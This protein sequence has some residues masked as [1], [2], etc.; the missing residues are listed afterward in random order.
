MSYENKNE[1]IIDIDCFDE[2]AKVSHY[3]SHVTRT[4]LNYIIKNVLRDC[5]L[6]AWSHFQFQNN[7]DGFYFCKKI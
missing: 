4:W 3:V 6:I 5:N 2:K 7:I 1:K